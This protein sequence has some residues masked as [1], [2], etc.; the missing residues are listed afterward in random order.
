[1][2]AWCRLVLLRGQLGDT[3]MSDGFSARG[4]P[5]LCD[6]I[7]NSSWFRSFIIAVIVFAGI[8]VGL[9]TYPEILAKHGDLLL[10]LDNLVLAI[11]VV[12]ITI[13]MIAYGDRPWHFFCDGWN[14]FDFVIVAVCLLPLHVEFVA[15]LRLAR[16]LR[17]LRLVSVLPRL[18]ILVGALLKSIPSIGYITV[19]LFLDFYIYACIGTFLFGENDPY[20]FGTMGKS[21]VTLFKIVTLE[22]WVDLMEIQVHGSHIWPY[23]YGVVPSNPQARP[24]AAV[25]YFVSFILFGTMIIL[26]LFIGVIMNAMAEVQAEAEIK[27]YLQRADDDVLT[28]P[29]E[30]HVILR[31]V[32]SLQKQLQRIYHRCGEPS[33][34]S[35]T[36]EGAVVTDVSTREGTSG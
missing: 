14:V 2:S 30:V 25:F 24:F 17:I 32:Q 22:G 12:E 35:E 1:M 13:R 4:V 3:Q 26:N 33:G 15:V 5:A 29:E 31:D 34:V 20:H 19:L 27:G 8:L 36:E 11:F 16:I 6:R 23:E 18:Q 28:L 9:E 21:M 7:A 10:R